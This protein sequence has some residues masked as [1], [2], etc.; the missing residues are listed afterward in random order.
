LIFEV[1]CKPPPFS[2]HH[3]K[4]QALEL[5][6]RMWPASQLSTFL[7]AIVVFPEAR[8]SSGGQVLLLEWFEFF[9]AV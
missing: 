8:G 2:P 9:V 5:G 4:L 3:Y 7:G 1:D 6:W